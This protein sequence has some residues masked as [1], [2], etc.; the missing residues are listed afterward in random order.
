MDEVKAIVEPTLIAL[1]QQPCKLDG[2]YLEQLE[3]FKTSVLFVWRQELQ[4]DFSPD[5]AKAWFT[6]LNFINIKLGEDRQQRKG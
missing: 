3:S 6:D 5:V 1:G 2:F 4:D